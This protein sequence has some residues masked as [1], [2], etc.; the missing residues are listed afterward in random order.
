MKFRREQERQ[1]RDAKKVSQKGERQK[2]R[3]KRERSA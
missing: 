2:E 3:V 1:L